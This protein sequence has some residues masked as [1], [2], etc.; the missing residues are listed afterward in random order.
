MKQVTQHNKTGEVRVEQ[1]P[2]PALKAGYLLVKTRYS[3]ISAGTEKA[4]ITQRKSSLL[5]KARAHPELVLRV[6]E[7]VKQYGLLATYRRVNA[8]LETSAPI[9]YST[10]GVVVAVG[11]GIAG[12]KP[13]DRVA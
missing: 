7:Q 8:R 12:F 2:L 9:G 6:L 3:V 4:S 10:S 5:Q 1:V 11:G 13:G